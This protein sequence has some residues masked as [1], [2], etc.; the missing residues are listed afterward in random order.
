MKGGGK[1]RCDTKYP[2]FLIHG[3]G[4]RENKHIGYWGRIPKALSDNGATVICSEQDANGSIIGNAEQIQKQLLAFLNETGTEKVNIIAHS[5]GGLEAR[6]LI[7]S[8]G[9]ADRVASLTTV[10]TPHNGS[11]TVDRLMKL[12]QGLVRFGCGA[13]NLWFR[14]LGDSSPDTYNAVCS[15]RTADAERF[16]AENPDA[17][18]I[19]YQS[20]AFVMKNMLSDIFMWLP[21]LV[22][23]HYEGENDGL[24][25]PDAVKWT[26]FKG[27]IRSAGRRGISHCDEVDMRR[28]KLSKKSDNIGI[29]DITEFYVSVAE[30]LK[31]MGF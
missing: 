30:D 5:K 16:N 3:M 4:F 28:S 14:I 29:D 9:M 11:K 31:G 2:I 19:Y 26:N 12:P 25:A 7:S 6:Y 27:I 1:M 18:G 15:F 24:L 8:M 22:V 21:W 13:V 10:S 20:Y 17:D 23:R